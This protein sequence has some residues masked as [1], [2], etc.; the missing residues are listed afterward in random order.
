[1]K[2]QR[3]NENRQRKVNAVL[4]RAKAQGLVDERGQATSPEAEAQLERELKRAAPEVV[5]LMRL[6]KEGR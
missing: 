3:E 2:A 5:E 1:M 4:D 6:L